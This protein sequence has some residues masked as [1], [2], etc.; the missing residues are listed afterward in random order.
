MYT[1]INASGGTQS[2]VIRG[3]GP[4][5][6]VTVLKG[7][8]A[9]VAWNGSDF[10]K[11]SSIGGSLTLLDLTVTGNTILGDAAADTLTVNAT[12]THTAPTSFSGQVKL[13]STGRS[14]AAAL[15][16]TNPAFLYGVASTYT[17]TTSSGTLAPVASF[18]G[19][20]QP[21]LSTSNVTTYTSAATLYIA[22]APTTGG[23]ATITNPYSLYVAAGAA[24]FGGGISGSTV[25]N[26]GTANGVA[27]LNASKVL[28]TG[29]ALTFDG[30]N[31]A[32][33][34]SISTTISS[35]TAQFNAAGGS[36]YAQFADG[37]TTWRLGTG[38]QSAGQ[39]NLYDVTNAQTALTFSP[40]A[41]GY[42]A[43]LQ[44]NSE[45]MRLTSTGLGIGTSSPGAK[46]HVESASAESVRIGYSS[47]KTAR[48][49][50]TSAGNL[51]V[52]AFDSTAVSYKNI[53]LAVDGSTSAGLVGVGTSSPVYKLVVSN[54]GASGI[55]FGPAF[56]GTSNLI[57]SYNRSGSAYVDT[58]Y[59]AS[60]HAFN[61]SGTEGMRLTSTGLGIGTSSPGYKLDVLGLSNFSKTKSGT[62]VESYDLINLRLNGTNAIGDSSNI[63]WYSSG[64]KTAGISG[65]CGA[66]N[67]AYGSI[68]F[69]VRRFT[70]DT[71]D[72]AMR[73]DNRG[74]LG[75]GVTPSAWGSGW[76][77][78]ANKLYGDY[79]SNNGGF[80]GLSANAYY[81]GT[82]WI[83]KNTTNANRFESTLDSFRWY[84]A[85]SGTAGNAI[86]FTQAMTLDTSG[87]LL[88]GTT[89][90]IL[91]TKISLQTG[92]G[93]GY[94]FNDTSS[95]A[96]TKAMVFGSGGTEV[97]SIS[98]T[99]VLTSY[100]TTSD[101]RLKE[102]IVDA[103]EFGSV[104]D[105]IKVRSYDW[106]TEG[107]HQRA[108][109]VAQE[110]VTVAPEAV[111][112]P[113]DPEEMMAVDYSKLVPML[114]K[115]IQS[116]RKRLAALEST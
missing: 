39:F 3:V 30:T 28:T 18:Y 111:H 14:A 96:G 45:Q 26:D 40:G 74:N 33:T 84:T 68:A 75:L 104:I 31:L 86:T 43:F 37:T 7:E 61:I 9:L 1:V 78:Y 67:I 109:F 113:A 60:N 71:Y 58:F 2:I 112:Q 27:Y 44:N 70:T 10:V 100:N 25:F 29:S 79:Y 21:T 108:G 13:P 59:D 81:D 114:V 72:E 85:P 8:S 56:S 89:S 107:S 82:N 65:I 66:D 87:N 32:A 101:Q 94:G 105:S 49:G 22:N 54:G 98:L 5:T 36:I 19:L 17:D 77:S 38:I 4:T 80:V 63:V 93:R 62:G 69:S 47:T 16:P 20:A 83:Y 64:I 97:G 35:K 73:I 99:S 110:L 103:P 88:V 115:E 51:Q 6:G 42:T 41:S 48:L 55:E 91:S 34:G 46:L 15:T 92:G 106:K 102:N 116:L 95:G 76:N 57:Q 50:V 24:Y 12:T 23:S 11:V 90:Q 52:Y 53:L